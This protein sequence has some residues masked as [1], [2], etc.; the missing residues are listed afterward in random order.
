MIPILFEADATDFRTNGIGRLT[1]CTSCLVTEQRN[2]VYECA[3]T[4]PVT[5]ALY[6]EIIEGR[7]IVVTHD[8]KGDKQP[9]IIYAR[10]APINGVVEFA[11]HHISYKA[12]GIIVP[13]MTAATAAEA[14]RKMQT[15]ALTANPFTLWTDKTNNGSFSVEV[16]SSIRSLL[17]GS[18]GSILDVFGGEY[19]WDKY[20]IKLFAHRGENRGVTIRYGKNLTD[21]RYE[22]NAMGLYNA[23]IPYWKRD[24]TVVRG[25]VVTSPEEVPAIA[26]AVHTLDLSSAFDEEPT[27]EQLEARAAS[28]LS[29]NTPW[30]PKTNLK[31]SF[32]ALWQTEEYKNIAPLERVR[33]C[34]TVSVYYPAI[35][36]NAQTKVIEVVWDALLDRYESM[37]L[38]DA[39][40]SFADT[41]ISQTENMLADVPDES[42]MQQAIDYATEQITGGM[43]GNVVLTRDANG[44]P[45]ELL[46]MDTKDKTTAVNVWRW[47]I[48]GLGHSHDGYDGPFGDFAITQDGH[49]NANFITVGTLSANV[50]AANSI[51]VSKLTGS[52]AN[53]GWEIDL[54]NGTLTIGNISASNINTGTLSVDRIGSNSV[55][56]DKLTGTITNS[57]WSINL[58]NGTLTIGTIS[59]DNIVSGTLTLGGSGTKANGVLEVRNSSNT[60][61]GSFSKNGITINSGTLTTTSGNQK[62]IIGSGVSQ[63]YYGTTKIGEVGA[64][65]ANSDNGLVFTLSGQGDYIGWFNQN[66]NNPI[67]IY[68]KSAW[69]TQDI[70]DY[71]LTA[72][73]NLHIAD[74]YTLDTSCIK[75]PEWKLGGTNYAGYTGNITINGIRMTFNRGVLT[76]AGS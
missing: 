41:I 45:I 27:A 76:S 63:Y 50:I 2:G 32:I 35:G 11:A 3:F 29:S 67:L 8:E 26:Q 70:W 44:Y 34:D 31:V 5:G 66:T 7:Q 1:E 47:N 30:I 10:S 62:T 40:M 68:D 74:G 9:F 48:G 55:T 73:C 22:T 13:P 61:L 59:A 57:G 46:L 36:V 18:E 12:A 49:L 33:L 15:I 20:I 64:N 60:L 58:T 6:S 53:N 42:M 65:T 71:A 4:Y 25:G 24:E 72:C 23:V 52:I 39:R 38:G 54:D 69:L 75:D 17:G 56:V 14:F 21:L 28:Y 37:E 51:S 16:P 43:G 19:E